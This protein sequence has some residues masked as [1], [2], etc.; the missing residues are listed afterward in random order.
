ME[1]ISPWI[2]VSFQIPAL[3]GSMVCSN[4]VVQGVSRYWR[5]SPTVVS[6]ERFAIA[7]H[8]ET[9]FIL[10]SSHRGSH[11]CRCWNVSILRNVSQQLGFWVLRS[12]RR[13]IVWPTQQDI[14]QSFLG[15][16]IIHYATNG[17][18]VL[19]A[20]DVLDTLIVLQ[21][22][23]RLRL[24]GMQARCSELLAYGRERL[25]WKTVAVGLAFMVEMS[26]ILFWNHC[27]TCICANHEHHSTR[28]MQEG[29][30]LS[31]S[32]QG[33]TI[34][35]FVWLVWAMLLF[36]DGTNWHTL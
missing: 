16:M 8:L 23:R 1:V 34:S 25:V 18:L 13:L 20:V 30:N 6:R 10:I 15:G 35:N 3:G 24:K 9:Y 4:K 36:G 21:G 19:E 12:G 2:T 5:R 32:R 26:F 11:N 27:L 22:M 31:H 17:Y 29:I 33:L 28:C 7:I 14:V